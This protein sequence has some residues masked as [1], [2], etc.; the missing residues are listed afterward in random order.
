M[1]PGNS[2]KDRTALALIKNG[3]EKGLLGKDNMNIYEG[4]SGSTGVSLTLIGNSL[5]CKC[6]LFL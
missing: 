6:K 2:M 3:F 4:T 1:N 5:G